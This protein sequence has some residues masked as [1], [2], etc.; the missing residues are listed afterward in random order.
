M[1]FRIEV[2]FSPTVVSSIVPANQAMFQNPEAKVWWCNRHSVLETRGRGWN[3]YK[4]IRSTRSHH[5]SV[6]AALP[7]EMHPTFQSRGRYIGHSI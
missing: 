1:L 2:G 5:I 6:L 7:G 4:V 3:T